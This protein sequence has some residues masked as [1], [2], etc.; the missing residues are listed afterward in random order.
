MSVALHSPGQKVVFV[1][2]DGIEAEV[3]ERVET[4]NLDAIAAT[5][6]YT[7]ACVGGERG[8]YSETPTISAP[9]YNNLITGT[10]ANKHNVR[11]NGIEAPNYN[12]WS[13]YR[14]V[15]ELAPEKE[16][17]IFSTWLDNRTKLIGEGLEATGKLKLD[18]AFD[19]FENDT[20]SFPHDKERLY[21]HLIDEHVVNE[22][23][24]YIKEIGPDFSWVYLEYTD[25]LGH[26]FGNSE[27]TDESI[28]IADRQIGKIWEAIE[29]RHN[30]LGEDWL[31]FITTDHGRSA[32]SGGKDHGGQSERERTTWIVMGNAG[33]NEYFN[34]HQNA[35]V[36]ILP[37]ALNYMDLE[38]PAAQRYEL[39]GVPLTGPVSVI[40]PTAGIKGQ[41]LQVGWKAMGKEEEVRI[42]LATTNDFATG[43]KD[44]YIELATIKASDERFEFDLTGYP[45][46]FYKVV[47]EGRFN[48]VNRWVKKE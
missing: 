32:E 20:I 28:R 46:D 2:V 24:R 9:G 17:A 43:G 39:D 3:I 12:Y 37:T 23:G 21:I 14:F 34:N 40:H 13:A 15:E 45:S 33:P 5:G 22:A 30:S 6:G 19:G 11:G 35:I 38:L 44:E 41:I 1:I 8:G 4:P 26:K 36:D 25:D 18:Y 7:R 47:I 48:S 29:H 31:I 10:W 16:T 27:E 42:L